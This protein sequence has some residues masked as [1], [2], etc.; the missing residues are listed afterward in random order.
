MPRPRHPKKAIE[1]LLAE[2]ETLGWIVEKRPGRGHAW[3][4]IRCPD[5]DPSCR[6]GAFCQMSIH[7][8]P[9]DADRHA[10]RLRQKA[11]RCTKPSVRGGK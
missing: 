3:G 10:A 2:L 4:L 1:Q 5:P 7:S 9:R 11:L 8:T 6:G